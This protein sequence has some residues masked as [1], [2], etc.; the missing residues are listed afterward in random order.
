MSQGVQP[1]ESEL[2]SAQVE[3]NLAGSQV[4]F[5]LTVPQAPVPAESILPILYTLTE[6]VQNSVAEARVGR[7]EDFLP[8]R[9]RG[10][11]PATGP[12]HANRGAPPRGAGRVPSRTEAVRGPRPIRRRG[13]TPR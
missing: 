3:M 9:L 1:D 7:Q 13:S 6:A 10:V 8:R 11:L 4:Q 5:T 2:V 12:D